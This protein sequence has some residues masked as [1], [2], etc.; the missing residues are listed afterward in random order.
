MLTSSLHYIDVTL[1]SIP[2]PRPLCN[3]YLARPN[4]DL[5]NSASYAYLAQPLPRHK[6][7]GSLPSATTTACSVRLAEFLGG[8]V[9]VKIALYKPVSATTVSRTSIAFALFMG[10]SPCAYC[11]AWRSICPVEGSWHRDLWIICVF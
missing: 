11:Y 6:G 10:E 2:I 3:I 4:V 7:I 5:M 8:E 1:E 9:L